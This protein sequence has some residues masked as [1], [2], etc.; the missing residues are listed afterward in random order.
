[1]SSAAQMAT[2]IAL[3]PPMPAP[4][5][6]WESVASVRPARGEKNRTKC[7]SKGR[8]YRRALSSRASEVKLSLRRVSRETSAIRREPR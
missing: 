6:A 8:R 7:A 5:G 1:M 2:A 4:A 3:E